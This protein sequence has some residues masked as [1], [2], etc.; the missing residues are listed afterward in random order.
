MR[1]WKRTAS[2]I[3]LILLL[4]SILTLVFHVEQAGVVENIASSSIQDRVISQLSD[5]K[6][7]VSASHSFIDVVEAKVL[8]VNSDSLQFEMKLNAIVPINPGQSVIAYL[9]LVD[10]D[11]NQ[12]TGQRHVFVGSEFNIRLA[13]YDCHWQGYIDAI[14]PPYIGGRVSV[15]VDNDTVSIIVGK[16]Q[17]GNVQH[18][19]WEISSFDDNAYDS[20]NSY[21]IAE[22]SSIPPDPGIV[23][24]VSLCPSFV[25][26]KD[27]IT[28]AWLSVT[29]NDVTG[30]CLYLF[31]SI[32]FFVDYPQMVSITDSGL[33]NA[34]IGKFGSCWVT[35]K[36]DGVL[37]Q[38][39]TEVRIGSVRLLPPI[40]LLSVLDNPT[41]T[42][43]L[44]VRDAYG[45]DVS[46]S[47]IRFSS[48]NPNVATV[49][50]SGLVTAIR[51]PQAFSETPYVT[52]WADCI[53]TNNAAVIRVTNDSLG[54]ILD[55]FWEEH[56]AFYVPRQPIQGFDYQKIFRDFDVVRITD[57]AYELEYEATQTTPFKGD[58][59]FLVND[60]GHGADGTVPC[61]LSGNP[62]RL[63]TDVDKPIHDSCMIVAYGSGSPQWGVYFHEMGHNFL[64]EGTKIWQFMSGHIYDRVYAEGLA[65][66][67]GMYS[68]KMLQQRSSLFNI[69]QNVLNNIVS[70]VWHFGL[71]PDLD[72]YLSKG[73]HYNEMT[74]SVLDDMIDVVCSSH[75]YDS[76]YRF[77]SLFLP[78]DTPF[79]FPVDSDA[80]Q[81]TL[82][83]AAL[84]ASTNED[85]RTQFV[86]WGFPIDNG[87]YEE[88]K[89]EVDVLV[90]QRELHDNNPPI[91]CHDY[92]GRWHD[93]DFIIKLMAFENFS[94]IYEIF[95]KI[96]D[97]LVLNV[98]ANGQ[99]LISL[100]HDN[101]TLEYWS[102]DKAGNEEL[103][104]KNLTGIK[105]DKTAPNGSITINNNTTYATST[106]V[107]L[108]LTAAD[109]VSGVYQ[110][111]CSNDG[112]W[113]TEPW[114][115]FSATKTWT[116][117]A[118]D[119]TKTVYYQVKDN[120]GL[121]SGTYSDSVILDT[122]DPKIEM[123]SRTPA[124]DVQP[125]QAV[126]ISVSIM[127][128]TS[129]IKNATAQY[130]TT[131]GTTWI[132]MPMNYN[133][134]TSSYEA[135]VPGQ[136]A[137]TWIKY[138]IIAYD[139]AEN[140]GVNDNA[141]EYFVYQ[142]V[143]EFS[144]ILS[145]LVF[146]LLTTLVL[147]TAKK[148]LLR[149][150]TAEHN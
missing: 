6:G 34:S 132:S 81:A 107:T 50:D 117:T 22:I 61:G 18:F 46:P 4:S 102:I 51:P 29:I 70:S 124:G 69:S 75:G 47:A 20:A 43:T 5:P 36:V 101:N 111:R 11:Q 122:T 109:I 55:G 91:T 1:L 32:K 140:Q 114:E 138:I 27:G 136:M 37:S 87:Y 112:I 95:Y 85:L 56:I 79:K 24:E 141:G 42:L 146:A 80:K 142:V 12:E 135:T 67:L 106:S 145:L 128:T 26:L 63:G 44:Q 134:S 147:I 125:N 108:T 13:F 129:G 99:P 49:S 116:L 133:F 21:A 150:I 28:K 9:W 103:P 93:Q 57:L 19:S 76:L 10:T 118:G 60:P 48:G 25:I 92:D 66:A 15:F 143:P 130:T 23:S 33:V 14:N 54:L 65:T 52:G 17:I 97:G 83:V 139:S 30:E 84:S 59:Q 72:Q 131:N 127:D 94:G 16:N 121:V 7:D 31:S 119:G 144:L 38:C 105:L 115:P 98:S 3:T 68:A 86:G 39:H 96:N 110:V 71:T 89:N 2:G 113:D 8:Q 53:E 137:G 45:N 104:H 90:N 64:G 77:F 62:I 123:P 78:R 149:K 126:L 88:I 82:F 148:K 41:G 35:A 58:I 40:L 74:P 100:E 120:A 73:A